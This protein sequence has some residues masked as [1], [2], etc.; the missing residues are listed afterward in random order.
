MFTGFF[1]NVWAQMSFQVC[2]HH[3]VTTFL[4]HATAKHCPSGDALTDTIWVSLL[5]KRLYMKFKP[6]L[7]NKLVCL[8]N[9]VTE[10]GA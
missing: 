2:V 6:A 5:K 9:N 8:M 3:T 10:K 7:K 4:S 1:I